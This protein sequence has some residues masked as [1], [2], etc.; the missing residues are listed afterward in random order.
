MARVLL[1]VVAGGGQPIRQALSD[2]EVIVVETM[3][4]ASQAILS[5]LFDLG[6]CDIC[7]DESRMFDL[8]SLVRKRSA[9]RQVRFI[10]YKEQEPALAEELE[11]VMR[12]SALN[13]GIAD[14]VDLQKYSLGKE[15]DRSSLTSLQRV[16]ESHLQSDA[17]TS[18]VAQRLFDGLGP[19]VRR[20]RIELGMS[21]EDL[22]LKADLNIALIHALEE[23]RGAD[24]GMQE[25][26]KLARALETFPSVL[27]REAEA[28]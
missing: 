7:F 28:V 6:V 22:A 18:G 16:L 27:L 13:M 20:H 19:T 8:W 24:L 5:G 3:K 12:G 26:W 2:H 9:G 11:R 25:L 17:C 14:Y 21:I 15:T 1:A 23:E 10:A 4:E